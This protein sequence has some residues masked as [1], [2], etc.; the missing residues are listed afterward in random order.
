MQIESQRDN[1]F[2]WTGRILL[3]DRSPGPAPQKL[4][5]A[6]LIRFGLNVFKMDHKIDGQVFFYPLDLYR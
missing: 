1:N 5:P 3:P 2:P 6:C 4:A